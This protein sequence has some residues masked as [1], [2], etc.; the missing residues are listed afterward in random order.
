MHSFML[1]AVATAGSAAPAGAHGSSDSM[2]AIAVLTLMALGGLAFRFLAP[3]ATRS[4]EDEDGDPGSGGGG[5]PRPPKR[6]P[7]PEGDPVWWPEF[8]RRFAAYVRSRSQEGRPTRRLNTHASAPPR[9]PF[10]AVGCKGV[11]IPV[12]VS[13][14]PYPEASVQRR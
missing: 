11:D 14:F 3:R 2:V 4:Q 13:G 6:P 7:S 9:G 12:L 5:G 10:A 1:A 8:E